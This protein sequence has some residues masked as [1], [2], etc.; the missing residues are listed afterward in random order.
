MNLK[1]E[2]LGKVGLDFML[3][4]MTS[5]RASHEAS[6]I[7]L[8]CNQLKNL[9]IDAEVIHDSIGPQS[10]YNA[11]ARYDTIFC[12]HGMASFPDEDKAF[13]SVA[14]KITDNRRKMVKKAPP[15]VN[16]Y[17]IGLERSSWYFERLIWP[18]FAHVRYVSLDFPMIP[19]GTR[20]RYK[21]TGDK[22]SPAWKAVNW[23]Q[24]Q[25]RCD[26]TVDWCID[27]YYDFGEAD[28]YHMTMGDSHAH[29]VYQP[30]SMVLRRDGRSMHAINKIGLLTELERARMDPKRVSSITSYYG[31]IDIRHH[32]C[33]QADPAAACDQLLRDYEEML[34][35]T[36]R[37]IELV[38]PVPIE[39]E[40]RQ[41]ASV[42]WYKGTPFYGSRAQ[43]QE[44][45]KRFIGTLEDMSVRNG[46]DL[47]AWPKWWYELDGVEFFKL[48]E[49]PRSVHLAWKNYRWDLIKNCANEY[50]HLDAD[51]S[52]AIKVRPAKGQADTTRTALL[53]F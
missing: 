2:Q 22:A 15:P 18:Q 39:D 41:V 46:W 12:Y 21:C 32:L 36:E 11:W 48:M 53:E 6:W 20:G 10:E 16:V 19:Y 45:V 43:R 4:H 40:S 50:E 7:Y 52:K 3:R 49:V 47:F 29:S 30:G 26:S 24:V 31:N 9:G 33:R 23:E 35:R 44:L 38:T 37:H 25:A 14:V 51:L 28:Q 27:P 8:R 13:G 42:G 5:N 34:K 1:K 17:D